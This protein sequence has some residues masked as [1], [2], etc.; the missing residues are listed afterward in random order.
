MLVPSQSHL[1]A[2]TGQRM[3]RVTDTVTMEPQKMEDTTTTTR[4]TLTDA[5]LGNFDPND[6]A[7]IA[8][9]GKAKA[10]QDADHSLTVWQAV[11]KYKTAA[12][13]AMFLS[14]ALVM[15]GFDLTIVS[16][17]RVTDAFRKQLL[18]TV[19]SLDW[20]I[21]RPD[22][23]PHSIR[24]VGSECGKICHQRCVGIRTVQLFRS[25]PGYRTRC[26]WLGPR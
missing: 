23:I 26:K 18:R 5:D 11:K 21:L 12:A 8:L 17:S 1:D 3:T 2:D 6:P 15:E 24:R 9:V 20:I 10:A 4:V 19:D 22:A 25:W 13:W 14:T 16:V 7:I